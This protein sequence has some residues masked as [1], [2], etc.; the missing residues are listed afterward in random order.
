MEVWHFAVLIAG[1]LFS[2]GAVYGGIRG[3][4]LRMHE[5]L[6][7]HEKAIDKL[8]SRVDDCV[9]CPGRRRGD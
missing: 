9:S 4:L 2:A 1:M 6:A 7:A 8:H 5:S 3:D